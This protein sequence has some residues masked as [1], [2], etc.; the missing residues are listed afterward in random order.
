MIKINNQ[1]ASS[2]SDHPTKS[3]VLA[4]P[5]SSLALATAC[6]RELCMPFF[7]NRYTHK[8]TYR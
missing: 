3:T 8:H 6:H 1:I 5:E 2:K 7:C 4:K